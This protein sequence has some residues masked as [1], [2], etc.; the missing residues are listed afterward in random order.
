LNQT[1]YH[2]TIFKRTEEEEDGRNDR[3][4]FST[5]ILKQ[6]VSKEKTKKVLLVPEG[7]QHWE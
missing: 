2:G 6:F 1:S 3:E 4:L 5:F 7:K